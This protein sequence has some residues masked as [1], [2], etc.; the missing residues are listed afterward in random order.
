MAF[1]VWYRAHRPE[2]IICH[3]AD[4]GAWLETVGPETTVIIL[5]A[6][7]GWP[8]SVDVRAG[9]VG[10]NAVECVADKIRRFDRGK[11]ANTRRHLIKGHWGEGVVLKESIAA[12]A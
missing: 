1:E 5:G 12:V 6:A 4:C 7:A 3:G 9:E 8:V 2:V 10:E 11:G